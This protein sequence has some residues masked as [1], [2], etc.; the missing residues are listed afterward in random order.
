MKDWRSEQYIQSIMQLRVDVVPINKWTK[1]MVGRLKYNMDI[2]LKEKSCWYWGVFPL[3]KSAL[4]RLKLNGRRPQTSVTRGEM[5]GLLR[6]RRWICD[7]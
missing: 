2:S 7:L 3:I 5:F 4:F 1:P 6:A